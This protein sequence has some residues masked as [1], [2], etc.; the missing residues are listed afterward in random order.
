MSDHRKQL[1][2]QIKLRV[3]VGRQPSGREGVKHRVCRKAATQPL[4]GNNSY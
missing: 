1:N 3:W 2:P 4:S